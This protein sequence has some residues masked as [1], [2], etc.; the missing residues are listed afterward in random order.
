MTVAAPVRFLDRTTPPHIFT[1]TLMAGIAA[2]NM[3]VFLPSL[4]MMAEHF[5][6]DYAVMQL[7]VSLYLAATAVLQIVIGPLSDRYG[8]RPVTLWSM[9]IFLAATLGCLLATD[10]VVFLVCRMVQASVAVG[11]VLSR[12][13][14]RDMVPPNEAASM[15]GYV[16]MG[17]A[18][19][20]M[21]APMIG[22]GLEQLFGWH[23]VF[24]L[25]LVCGLGVT[26][27]LWADQGE[28]AQR[29]S[30]S[31]RAQVRDYPEL[32]ASQR[33][34]GYAL[35]AAFASGAFFAFLGGAPY[36]AAEIYGMEPFWTG[37]AFGA[38]AVGY[39]TGN[40]L[41]G[42][43][44]VRVGIDRMMTI[45]A[46]LLLGGMSAMVLFGLMGASH[47]ALF[48][49]FATFVGLG[50]GM[51]IPNATSG[52]LSVRPHLAGTASGL[53]SAIMIGG[54]A[55][56]SVLAGIVLEGASSSLPLQ[57]LMWSTSAL[58]LACVLYVLHRARLVARSGE[59]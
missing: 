22:G 1:L 46:L 23:S 13:I 28:T 56:L 40:G 17:M 6:T 59:F 37:I 4:P 45:G 38:P 54:G 5:G 7:S 31:F 15:I 24:W 43:M 52:L 57:L 44:S 41:S 10:V 32:F 25:L 47:P 33:F 9:A 2:M 39:A 42:M 19:V 18:L 30:T 14:V 49:G 51:I 8:R 16:T 34:W 50:N 55:A 36:A 11:I 27:L 26:W 12:A 21:I 20:P 53:G 29:R 3:N 35:A 58:C 48:F